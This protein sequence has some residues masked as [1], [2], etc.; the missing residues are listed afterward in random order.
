MMEQKSHVEEEV[1]CLTRPREAHVILRAG[2][3]WE[4]EIRFEHN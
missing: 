3:R 4:I 2:R 1:N